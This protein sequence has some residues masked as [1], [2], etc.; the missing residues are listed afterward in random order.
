MGDNDGAPRRPV[1][2]IILDGFGANPAKVN[3]GIAEANTP[4]FDEYFSRYGHTVIEASGR[5]SGLPSGQMGNSEV[6]HITLG[7]GHLIRQDLVKID[8]SIADGSFFSNPALCGAMQQAKELGGCVHLVG[9]VSDGGVHSH[10]NHLIALINH[11][12]RFGVRPMVH[13]I[14]DG[15]DTPPRSALDY[16]P[17]VEQALEKANGAIATVSGRYYAMDRDHRWERTEK[18]WRAMVN[19]EGLQA[20]N[21]RDA[22]R[23]GYE[24]GENDEFI[25]PTVLAAHRPIRH[26]DAVIVFNFRKDRPRQ[27]V[28][29]MFQEA[30]IDFDRGSEYEPVRPVCMTKYDQWY[31]LPYAFERDQPVV[32]LG[33]YLSEMNLKQFRCAETEKFAHVTYFFNGGRSDPYPNEDRVIVPS[34]KVATYDLQPEMSAA[35]VADE[36]IKAIGK[37]EYA[38]ILVNFANGDMVGHTAVREAIIKAVET[39]DREVG[40]VLD[41]AVAHDYSVILTADHGNCDEMVDPNT[42]EPHTQHT[43]Y[44]VPCLIVDKHPWKLATGGALENVAPTVLHLMGLTRPQGMKA[45]SL[46]LAPIKDRY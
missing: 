36:V 45:G 20:E 39:L 41:A 13:M 2:L 9:L 3:N 17:C 42:G 25:T 21:A 4:R 37:E 11:T 32:T 6:G 34:P 15:R 5:A 19:A 30:F 27:L 8:D 33:K 7:A 44:P 16:L 28:A 46:L 31:G 24:R 1:M 12:T 43:V 29:A 18:A 35:Q 10:V 40:R 26:K 22:I 14:C 23:A 38:F